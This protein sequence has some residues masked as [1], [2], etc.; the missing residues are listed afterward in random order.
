[1]GTKDQFVPSP[2]PPRSVSQQSAPAVLQHDRAQ[3]VDLIS[4]NANS[5]SATFISVAQRAVSTFFIPTSSSQNAPSTS[6]SGKPLKVVS[7]LAGIALFVLVLQ[8]SI[9]PLSIALSIGAITWAATTVFMHYLNTW[10][11]LNLAAIE[12]ETRR[13][14]FKVTAQK[15]VM[16]EMLGRGQYHGAFPGS[17]MVSGLLDDGRRGG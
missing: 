5:D 14:E 7:A 17:S 13:H 16:V 3:S 6:K 1:M 9:A 11:T 8:Y 2:L 4:T 10:R 15:E 12:A